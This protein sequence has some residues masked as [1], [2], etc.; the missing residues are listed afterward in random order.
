MVT[1]SSQADVCDGPN[2]T[3]KMRLRNDINR[4]PT[5]MTV[6]MMNRSKLRS[7]ADSQISHSDKRSACLRYRNRLITDKTPHT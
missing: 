1:D 6:Y 3:A 2:L 5:I 4:M 7:D